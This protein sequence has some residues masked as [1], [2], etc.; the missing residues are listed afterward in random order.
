MGFEG[1]D[2]RVREPSSHLLIAPIGRT[3]SVRVIWQ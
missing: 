2:Q 3:V 1:Q